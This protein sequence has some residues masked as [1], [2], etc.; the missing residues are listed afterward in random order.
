MFVGPAAR[1]FKQYNVIPEGMEALMH[2]ANIENPVAE[3]K[4]SHTLKKYDPEG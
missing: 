2:Q 3:N 4:W 1:L